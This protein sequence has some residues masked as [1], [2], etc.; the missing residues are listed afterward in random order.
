ML[1]RQLVTGI[2][3]PTSPSLRNSANNNIASKCHA[4]VQAQYMNMLLVA[5]PAQALVYLT[6]LLLGAMAS[7]IRIPIKPTKVG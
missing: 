4:A 6:A 1:R 3:V 7:H 5:H 2:G